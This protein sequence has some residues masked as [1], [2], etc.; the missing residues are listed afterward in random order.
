MPAPLG[1]I[2]ACVEPGAHREGDLGERRDAAEA[3]RDPV[4]LE[5]VRGR[6]GGRARRRGRA[7]GGHP[8][9]AV[10]HLRAVG[11]LARAAGEGDAAHLEHDGAV[12]DGERHRRVLLDEHDGHALAV[13]LADD[14]ADLPDHLRRQAERRLIEQQHP[15][16][17]HQGAAD[18]QHL[19]LAPRQ[20]AGPL[21]R[22]FGEDREELVHP[23]PRPLTCALVGRREAARAQVLGDRQV[24]EDAPALGDLDD[25]G[26]G[27][28]RRAEAEQGAPGE[29]DSV[30]TRGATL[31]TEAYETRSGWVTFA[32]IVL[33]AVGFAR[34]FSA[35]SYFADSSDIANLTAGVFGDNL[36]AWGLWDLCIAALALFA[37]GGC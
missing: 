37:G 26:A 35:I 1:P 3:H 22:A 6:R 28:R 15:R 23:G 27:D 5:R 7:V 13:D 36:W 9:I 21:A 25:A 18:G 29:L 14:L 31:S 10:A 11:E 32:A 30:W 12:G 8:E 34:I 20:E 17:G 24:A 2:S 19:L 33:F 4:D 16:A